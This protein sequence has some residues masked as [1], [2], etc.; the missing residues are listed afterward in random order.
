MPDM[1]FTEKEKETVALCFSRLS[2]GTYAI[3][4]IIADKYGLDVD[5]EK[6][7]DFACSDNLDGEDFEKFMVATMIQDVTEILIL[8]SE[9]LVGAKW[10]MKYIGDISD[11]ISDNAKEAFEKNSKNVVSLAE[12]IIRKRTDGADIDIKIEREDE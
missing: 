9:K 11:T 2:I 8:F 12:E 6:F 3:L 1:T 10:H 7:I 4:D 5:G